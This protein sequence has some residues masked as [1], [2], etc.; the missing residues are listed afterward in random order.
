VTPRPAE[1]EEI[2]ASK[3]FGDIVALRLACDLPG[4]GD[5]GLFRMH[6]GPLGS[7]QFWE[8]FL[9]GV[10]SAPM[11]V[12]RLAHARAERWDRVDVTKMALQS[13]IIEAFQADEP[14]FRGDLAEL[15]GAS[16]FHQIKKPELI[17]LQAR[18]AAQWLVSSP[19][20]H[21]LVPETLATFLRGEKPPSIAGGPL[22]V[23]LPKRR[24]GPKS[25]I[26][27]RAAA[28]ML[29][30]LQRG[31][32]T[33]KSLGTEKQ[34]VLASRYGVLSRSTAIIALKRAASKFAAAAIPDK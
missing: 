1:I 33:V 16:Y 24:R 13:A 20:R 30:D 11:F 22:S 18:S 19:K 28:A 23:D 29:A 5:E 14:F 3:L 27:E 15:G 17:K 25:D 8:N 10:V 26:T 32:T 34:E 7:F 2:R 6:Y 31:A 12:Q 4:D 9:Y 21:H